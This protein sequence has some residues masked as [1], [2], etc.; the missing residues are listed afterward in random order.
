M[1]SYFLFL[2]SPPNRLQ[3]TQLSA[4]RGGKFA[5]N[6][7]EASEGSVFSVVKNRSA[8]PRRGP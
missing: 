3:Y 2:L 1:A 8:R 5:T 7:T 6:D 4:T